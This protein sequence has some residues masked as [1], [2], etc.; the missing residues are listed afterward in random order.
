MKFSLKPHSIDS[1]SLFPNFVHAFSPRSFERENGTRE[2]LALGRKTDPK[3][4]PQHREWFLK[5]LNI[6]SDELYLVKQ[7]HGDRVFVLDDPK[8]TVDQVELEEA[9]ALVT[10]MMEKPIAVLT[11]DCVPVIL[12]DPER[13]VAGVIHAG[14]KGTQKRIVSRTISILSMT[15]GSRPQ[16]VA[17]AF[18]PAIGGCCYEVEEACVA[19]FREQFSE[20]ETF[21]TANA[22]N[23]YMLDLLKANEADAIKAGILKK[24]IHRSSE[25]TCCNT[26][27]WFSYR[28]EGTTGRILSLALLRE[29]SDRV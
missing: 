11:A 7:V 9:D 18:G 3:S 8:K 14:R 15:Y 12:Y 2:E 10:Q 29:T 17:M 1:F 24:N 16:D 28:G 20:W 6:N 26:D 13:H 4:L 23:R 25:C 19:P 27:R 22:R 21:V 5:S